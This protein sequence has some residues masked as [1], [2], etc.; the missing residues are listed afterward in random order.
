MALFVA[1][2]ER[3]AHRRAISQR[4]SSFHVFEVESDQMLLEEIN[5][6]T[7]SINTDAAREKMPI[8]RCSFAT[9]DTSTLEKGPFRIQYGI[10][11]TLTSSYSV[12]LRMVQNFINC[13]T[14][15]NLH[16]VLTDK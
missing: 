8:D 16:K 7:Q 14:I 10:Q 1:H 13:W 15:V 5:K 12:Q 4:T 3:F 2:V 11:H 6:V 9:P